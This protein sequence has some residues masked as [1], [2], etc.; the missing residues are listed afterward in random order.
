MSENLILIHSSFRW[1]VVTSLLIALYTAAT[2]YLQKRKFT[3]IDNAIRHWTATIAHI[4]LMIGMLLY[5]ES[6][7]TAYFRK[8]FSTAKEHFDLVFFGAIHG[9]FMFTAILVITFGS[10]I[11]KKKATDETKFKAML[12]WYLI[13][14]LIIFMAI[15][16]PFSPLVN[17]PYLR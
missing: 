11:T 6:P 2:G 15:P 16:W 17:R 1:L 7:L 10:A 3:S 13:A 9:S 14:F 12:I 4:Q 8:N 5:F